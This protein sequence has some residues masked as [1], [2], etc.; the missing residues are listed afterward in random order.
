MKLLKLVM[1]TIKNLQLKDQMYF[2]TR[3]IL[4][5]GIEK[6]LQA[7]TNINEHIKRIKFH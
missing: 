2:S 1:L 3:T 6:I 5:K 4:H 7:K